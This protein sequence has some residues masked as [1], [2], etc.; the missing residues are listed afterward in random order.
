MAPLELDT[1]LVRHPTP[2]LAA[3]AV[4]GLNPKKGP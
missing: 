3:E 2:L 1:E 4:H